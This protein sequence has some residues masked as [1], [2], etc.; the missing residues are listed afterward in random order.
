MWQHKKQA[1][2]L[3]TIMTIALVGCGPEPLVFEPEDNT[4]NNSTSN[5]NTSTTMDMGFIGGE[6]NM[7]DLGGNN[8][9]TPDLGTPNTGTGTPN[10]NCEVDATECVDEQ[11]FRT[12]TPNGEGGSVWSQPSYCPFSICV[13]ELGLCCD[14][15]CPGEG[16]KQCGNGGVQ[17]CEMQNGCLVWSEP[18]P[19]LEG[20]FC[21][22]QGVCQAQCQSQ[23]AQG[24]QRCVTEG[25]QTYQKCEDIGGGC[26]QFAAST[27][28]CGAGS[29]CNNGD[30]VRE[31]NNTCS[32]LG[33]KRCQGSVEQEC[34]T[35]ADGCLD[36]VNTGNAT[37]C[38]PTCTDRCTTEDATRCDANNNEQTCS[39]QAT[40]CLDWVNTGTCVVLDPCYSSSLGGIYVDHGT[41]VQNADTNTYHTCDNGDF[42]CL[43]AFCNNGSWEYQ[44]P[45]GNQGPCATATTKYPNN[46]CGG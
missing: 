36:W 45:Q 8:T 9:T 7:P 16:E 23:C 32:M 40:G 24:D 15:P 21:T 19:C 4:A 17:T 39:R 5:P 10:D 20:G 3:F 35:Q 29:T 11:R 33:D 26:F 25:G 42:G 38:G 12:C 44:C 34:V 30:C 14:E 43:W 46:T 1:G 18:E 27:F 31:C 6:G 28:N 2:Y 13:D 37:A 41:C 22:G